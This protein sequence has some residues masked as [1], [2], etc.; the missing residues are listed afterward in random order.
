MDM[1]F[2]YVLARFCLMVPSR[3][4]KVREKRLERVVVRSLNLKKRPVGGS[5]GEKA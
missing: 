1:S 3:G 4:N 2:R 5:L